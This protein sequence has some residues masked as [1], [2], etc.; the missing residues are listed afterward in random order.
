MCASRWLWGVD[1]YAG[2]GYSPRKAWVLQCL[3]QLADMYAIDL[4]R[5]AVMSNH[6]HLVAHHDDNR[7]VSTCGVVSI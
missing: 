2:R 6:Y 1:E 3:E 7:W 4:L 5:H